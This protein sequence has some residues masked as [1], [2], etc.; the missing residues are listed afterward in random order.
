MR[1]EVVVE[2]LL[3][4]FAS[5]STSALSVT[6][7]GVGSDYYGFTGSGYAA[8]TT[9]EPGRAYWVYVTGATTISIP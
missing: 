6:G 7:A 4:S 1:A 2:L 3:Q 9:L 5:V 8:V